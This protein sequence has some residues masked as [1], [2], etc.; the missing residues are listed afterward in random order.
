MGGAAAAA[1]AGEG[2]ASVRVGLK[3]LRLATVEKVPG[4]SGASAVSPAGA[5]PAGRARTVVAAGGAVT[6]RTTYTTAAAE[7]ATRSRFRASSEREVAFV[8]GSAA[9]LDG[10]GG[11]SMRLNFSG[12]GEAAISEGVRRLGQAVAFMEELHQ[13][14]RPGGA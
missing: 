9:Y 13:S 4:G 1:L 14:L 5:A 6:S 10:R 2:G 7:T 8:P 3:R 12:V 11:S